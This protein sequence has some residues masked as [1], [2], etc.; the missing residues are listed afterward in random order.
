MQFFELVFRH[1]RSWP[2]GLK[3][4]GRRNRQKRISIFHCGMRSAFVCFIFFV[5]IVNGLNC[6]F[7]VQD[8]FY[9]LTEISLENNGAGYLH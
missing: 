3:T 8:Y 6:T 9:N 5:V 2:N 4:H 1:A 7:Q